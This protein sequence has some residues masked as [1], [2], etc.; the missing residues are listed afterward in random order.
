MRSHPTPLAIYRTYSPYP[1]SFFIIALMMWFWWLWGL[2]MQTHY[3]PQGDLR[4]GLAYFLLTAV[5]MISSPYI[6]HYALR[7]RFEKQAYYQEKLQQ[8]QSQA[9]AQEYA[10]VARY[11]R[12]HGH[13]PYDIPRLMTLAMLFLI[14]LFDLFFL[15]AWVDKNGVMVWQPEWAKSIIKWAIERTH[16]NALDIENIFSEFRLF[17][18]PN[19]PDK[20]PNKAE[21]IQKFIRTQQGQT[22]MFFHTVSVVN[23]L[24]YVLGV[25]FVLLPLLPSQPTMQPTRFLRT[26]GR[27]IWLAVRSCIP[28]GCTFLIL[29][30]FSAVGSTAD[31]FHYAGWIDHIW[32]VYLLLGIM[33]FWSL[34]SIVV[35]LLFWEQVLRQFKVWLDSL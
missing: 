9:T 7:H 31:K 26:I 28:F 12:Q 18:A 33:P 27:A 6:Y 3:Y 29:A 24:I 15:S 16:S 34:W 25:C 10:I 17:D 8:L 1:K 30:L 14:V 21:L 20:A 5:L 32:F 2:D 11:V 19:I 4:H 23:Y 35:Y 13:F 22:L